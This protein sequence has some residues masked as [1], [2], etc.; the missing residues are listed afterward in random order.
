[1]NV[2]P[3]FAPIVA[4]LTKMYGKQVPGGYEIFIPHHIISE[5]SPT[6]QIQQQPDDPN[7]HGV[8]LRYLPN[9]I[10]DG[11]FELVTEPDTSLSNSSLLPNFG[12]PPIT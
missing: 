3:N 10:I 2:V 5:L 9:H 4:S 7:E 6:G 1:M 8:R 11:K 12:S